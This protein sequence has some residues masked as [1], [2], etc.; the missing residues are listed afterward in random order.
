MF[1]PLCQAEYLA[2][3]VQCGDCH[4]DLVRSAD[5]A[6]SESARFWKGDRQHLLDQVLAALDS[7]EI[8]SH[9]EE[10]ISVSPRISVFGISLTPG[11]STFQYEVRV[12]RSDINR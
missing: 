10:L 1:C 8:P 2:G 5:E 9:F 4:V 3:V 12:L 7:Q 11:K 6:Q